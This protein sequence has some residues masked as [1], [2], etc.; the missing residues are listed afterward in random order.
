[1]E[2]ATFSNKRE[3]NLVGVFCKTEKEKAPCVVIC[4]G[5]GSSKD[6]K[7][8]LME[9]FSQAGLA[10][11]A[12]D[13]SGHG[14]SEGKFE[15]V[16]T[17]NAVEDLKSAIDFV[18]QLDG[19]DKNRIGVMGHS[20]GGSVSLMAAANDKRIKSIVASAPVID[21][22]ETLTLLADFDTRMGNLTVWKDKGYTHYFS[23]NKYMKLGYPFLEDALKYDA[24]KLAK[25][26]KCPV[27]LIHGRKDKIVPLQ[28]SEKMLNLLS[29]E[30]DLKELECGH[31]F[32][33]QDLKNLIEFS[34]SWFIKW[35]R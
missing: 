7:S 21:F 33:E 14:E 29:C 17:T 2:K 20:F 31:D 1:M 28:Q 12:F 9:A 16:T 5:L 30:K 11:L 19:I 15:Y 6:N 4:H 22:N 27:L 18:C 26:I 3:E 10:S 35:L 24:K 13:F 34:Q 8:I 25:K 32:E 23:S